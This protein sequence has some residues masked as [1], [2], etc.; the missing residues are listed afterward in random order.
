M[1]RLVRRCR[2]C[3]ED[4][5]VDAAVERC[6][7]CGS[8]FGP[9]VFGLDRDP[10]EVWQQQREAADARWRESIKKASI[11]RWRS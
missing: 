2:E 4:H 8:E 11:E 6:P 9:I 1:P 10:D 5:T 7:T 3:N